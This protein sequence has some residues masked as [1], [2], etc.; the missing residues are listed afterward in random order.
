MC[1]RYVDRITIQR[2][3]LVICTS[4][5]LNSRGILRLAFCKSSFVERISVR[6]GLAYKLLFKPCKG[7]ASN[8]STKLF[9][10][11]Y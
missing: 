7:L 5:V 8:A 4:H 3:R 11:I 9:I 6:K 10:T 1:G 2:E